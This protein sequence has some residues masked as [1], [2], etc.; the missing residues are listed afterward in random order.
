MVVLR[1]VMGVSVARLEGT[2]TGSVTL[3]H[4]GQ[5]QRY[6]D[7]GVAAQAALGTPVPLAELSY[8]VRGAPGSGPYTQDESGFTQAGWSV[9]QVPGEDGLPKRLVMHQGAARFVLAIRSWQ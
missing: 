2:P 3:H 7:L 5:E 9:T 6:A 4:R 8:W 1:T